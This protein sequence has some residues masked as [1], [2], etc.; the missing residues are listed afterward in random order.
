MGDLVECEIHG[1][2]ALIALNNP[3]VNAMG[4]AVRQGIADTLAK[5]EA[6]LNIKAIVLTGGIVIY[7]RNAAVVALRAELCCLAAVRGRQV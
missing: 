3:P 1:S 6:D 4:V 2:I 5:A 7:G